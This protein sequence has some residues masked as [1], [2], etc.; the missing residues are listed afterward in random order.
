MG[1]IRGKRP[2][3]ACYPRSEMSDNLPEPWL[4]GPIEGVDPT[5]APLLRSLE[6][7]REDLAKFTAGLS[8]EQVWARPH[9]LAP[10]GFQL[11]HIAGSTDRLTTYLEGKQLTAEQIATM[12]AE[13]EPGAS[14]EELLAAIDASFRHTEEVA[15]TL[16]PAEFAAFRGVGRKNLPTTVIGLI[17]HIAEHTQRHVG[18]AIAAAKLARAG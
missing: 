5:I 12:K 1:G 10:L 4:R 3:L 13:M 8:T 17:V 7:A 18:Q 15:K 14:L 6:Q 16:A 11:R 2:R 9:G